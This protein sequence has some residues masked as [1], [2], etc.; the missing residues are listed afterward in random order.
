MNINLKQSLIATVGIAVIFLSSCSKDKHVAPEEPVV[1][2]KGVFILNEGSMNNNNSSLSYVGSETNKVT[3]DIFS[4]NNKDQTLGAGASDMD[5]YGNL[6]FIAV[7]ESNKVEILDA[8]TARV[9]KKVVVN[10]PRFIAFHSGKAFITTYENKVVV[11]DTLTKTVV[12]NGIPVGN[13]PEHIVVSGNKLYVANSGAHDFMAGEAYESTVS[14]IDPV[15]LKEESKIKVDDNV[16]QL[17]ADGKGNIYG[18]TVDIYNGDWSA[19]INPSHLFR[20]NTSTN[21]VDKTFAFGVSHMAFYQDGAIFISNNYEE[22]NTDLYAMSLS[23]LEPKKLDIINAK[24]LNY[25]NYP[26]A[27]S[28][29]PENGDIWYANSD[30]S[31]PGTVFHYN[32]ISK[33]VKNYTVGLNPSVFVFK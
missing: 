32:N 5:I 33:D 26:Y 8:S 2:L 6:L 25:P 4:A 27:L 19:I 9:I 29:N 21:K 1:P 11:I 16:Y 30:Y 3:T 17:F 13:T 31:N 7:T 12:G 24:D 28:V 14:V 10:Q 15:T 22:D 23:S 20:I 18:N